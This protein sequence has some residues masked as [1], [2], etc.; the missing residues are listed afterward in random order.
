M[1]TEDSG[2]HMLPQSAHAD[3]SARTTSNQILVLCGKLFKTCSARISSET[4]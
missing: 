3:M 4:R 1:K 2:V